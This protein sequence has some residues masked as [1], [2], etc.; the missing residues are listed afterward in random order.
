MHVYPRA[1]GAGDF[2]TPG[3]FYAIINWV[4]ILAPLGGGTF[5]FTR[6]AFDVY[7]RQEIRSRKHL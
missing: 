1:N 5:V 7:T 2:L 4:S 3:G 6:A